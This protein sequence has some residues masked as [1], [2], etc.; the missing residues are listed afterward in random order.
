MQLSNINL[1]LGGSPMHVIHKQGVTPAEILVL[2]RIHGNDAVVDVRPTKIDKNRRHAEEFDRLAHLYDRGAGVETPDTDQKSIL[3]ELFPG[4]M[5]KLPVSLKEIGFGHV[6]SPAAIAE[7]D[8]KDAAIV[9]SSEDAD[10]GPRTQ[11]D[12]EGAADDEA[13]DE[14]D[15]FAAGIAVAVK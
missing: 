12:I 11:E 15:V 5:K 10:L 8:A 3:K 2:Q 4:A 1:R 7:L 13:E 9:K 14:D 6:L